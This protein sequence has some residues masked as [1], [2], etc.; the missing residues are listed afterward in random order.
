MQFVTL[1][2][3]GESAYLGLN[4]ERDVIFTSRC[5]GCKWRYAETWGITEALLI[6]INIIRD[7]FSK[8]YFKG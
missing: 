2:G 7:Y 6:L 8:Y 3:R 1:L 5:N 4:I